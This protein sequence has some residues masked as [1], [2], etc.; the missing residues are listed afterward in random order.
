LRGTAG[1]GETDGETVLMPT[2]P[3]KHAKGSVAEGEAGK[4]SKYFEAG[5]K[6]K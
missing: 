2:K 6:A 3:T 1:A 5:K 4:K